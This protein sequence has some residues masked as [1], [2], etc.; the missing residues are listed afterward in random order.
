MSDRS[1][2]IAQELKRT[3]RVQEQ[4]S[5]PAASVWVSANAGTGRRT[6]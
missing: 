5:D 4:A 6:F 3:A 1:A 2:A